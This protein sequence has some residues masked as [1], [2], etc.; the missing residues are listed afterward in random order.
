MSQPQHFRAKLADKVILNPKFVHYFFE[1][2]EPNRMEFDAGQYVSIELPNADGQRRPYSIVSS[3]EKD[4]G[5][6]L[7]VDIAPNGLGVKYLNN[8]KF[9]E[10]MKVLAPMGMF[11]IDPEV[12]NRNPLAFI[13]TGAGIAPFRSM[14]LDELQI[15]K[16]TQPITLYWGMRHV[17]E[18]FWEND[19]AE[20]SQS[21]P[22]FRIHPVISQPLPEWPL[23][24]G[25]VTDCLSV[26]ELLPNADYYLC[27]NDTMI[28]NVMSL[29]QTKNV[30]K[31]KMHRERFY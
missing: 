22:N 11:V 25:R 30:P 10:E 24:R 5:F 1:L 16:N 8:L 26:H 31:E 14:I 6:E 7:L 20:I 19:F 3:P 12:V 15:K 18:L 23:C 27:G 21:F 13:A 2:V 4:H 9:G 29:L 17:E 28:A